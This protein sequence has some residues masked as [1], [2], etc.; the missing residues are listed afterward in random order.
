MVRDLVYRKGQRREPAADDVEFVSE[1][2]GWLPFAAPSCW[3][4]LSH[5]S[6]KVLSA[7]LASASERTFSFRCLIASSSPAP[8]PVSNTPK[9][10]LRCGRENVLAEFCLEY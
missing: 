6:A 3:R 8:E 10:S 1:R 5:S 4:F 2:I 9:S 7:L